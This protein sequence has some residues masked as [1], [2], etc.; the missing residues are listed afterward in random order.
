MA[1]A[2]IATVKVAHVRP[3]RIAIAADKSVADANE[4]ADGNTIDSPRPHDDVVA[5]KQQ[6]LDEPIN[7]HQNAAN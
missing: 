7:A 2:N 4:R 5:S 6:Q 1:V 3:N